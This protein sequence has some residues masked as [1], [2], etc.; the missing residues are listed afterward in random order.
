MGSPGQVLV[1]AQRHRDALLRMERGAASQ[2]VRAYGGIWVR[3]RRE[4]EDVLSRYEGTQG[5]DAQTSLD[6]LLDQ[7][8]L[9]R[10]LQQ[11]ERQINRFAAVADGRIKRGQRAAIEA[12]QASAQAMVQ[13]QA[14]LQIEWN[15]LPTEMI[16]TL[17]GTTA[18]GSPLRALLDQLG[19][20]ASAS[21]RKGLIEGM[22]LGENPRSVA[23]RIRR[24]LGGNLAKALTISR[25]EM[26]RAAREASRQSYLANSD[27]LDGWKWLSAKQTRTCA[28]CL[29]M[30][31]TLHALEE[32]L[33]D[34]PNGRCTSIPVVKGAPPVEW[35]SGSAWFAKQ[36]EATQ[37]SMLGGASFEAY[38][39]GAIALG[40]FVGQ[41]STAAWGTTRYSKSLEGIVGP[42]QAASWKATAFQLKTSTRRLG[43]RSKR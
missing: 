10:L 16:E 11:T 5:A 14:G 4:I 3:L 2:M 30:D 15:R 33:D 17:V 13:T 21:V 19:P 12:A 18:N 36:D 42:R 39:A 22:G 31:G 24:S 35:E 9:Q 7:D 29:A 37:R 6:W 40:D 20:H 41:T 8:R 28:M 26:L 32:V 25:T 38:H 34:H 1:I 27:I 43:W 23:E